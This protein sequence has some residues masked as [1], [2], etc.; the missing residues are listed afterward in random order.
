MDASWKRPE[1]RPCPQ[2]RTRY[3]VSR[4][5]QLISFQVVHARVISGLCAPAG[6]FN[7]QRT[8]RKQRKRTLPK[9][10]RFGYE[11][12]RVG[13]VKLRRTAGRL[14]LPLDASRDHAAR[15]RPVR[16]PGMHAET[17]RKF[18]RRPELLGRGLPAPQPP[19]RQSGG[20]DSKGQP[21]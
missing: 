21:K 4:S 8:K 6:T 11:A 9:I 14:H 15:S 20:Q 5:S 13:L 17:F 3:F 16:L 1:A 18:L 10:R 7:L 12:L 19:I 2:L